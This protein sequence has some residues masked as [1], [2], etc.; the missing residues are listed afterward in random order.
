MKTLTTLDNNTLAALSDDPNPENVSPDLLRE[1]AETLLQLRFTEES[2]ADLVNLLVR[3]P[4]Y[5]GAS[6]LTPRDALKLAEA[7]TLCGLVVSADE[8]IIPVVGV[9]PMPEG[10]EFAS[11]PEYFTY[12]AFVH[13]ALSTYARVHGLKP[14]TFSQK[15][16]TV[17]TMW[18]KTLKEWNK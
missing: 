2:R 5:D 6:G 12:S 11:Q 15:I 8:K 17:R 18:A 16:R 13:D 14:P 9:P 4:Y 1:M 3:F 7:L 10:Y